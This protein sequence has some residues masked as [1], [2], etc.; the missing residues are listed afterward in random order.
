[1]VQQFL[2]EVLV[3]R[4]SAIAAIFVT[5]IVLSIASTGHACEDSVSL[6]AA[7]GLDSFI[8]CAIGLLVNAVLIARWRARPSKGAGLSLIACM[9]LVLIVLERQQLRATMSCVPSTSARPGVFGDHYAGSPAGEPISRN[10][11]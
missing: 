7:Y 8:G 1:M 3:V 5:A 6:L 4:K 9:R 11:F 10:A 2:V